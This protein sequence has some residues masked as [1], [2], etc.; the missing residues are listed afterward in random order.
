MW[1][2]RAAVMSWGCPGLAVEIQIRRPPGP[3]GQPVQ[4]RPQRLRPAP[5]LD[6]QAEHLAD[7]PDR[8]RPGRLPWTS[9]FGGASDR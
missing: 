6:R 7:G 2:W 9:G 3:V 5:H 4:L 1:S 8:D